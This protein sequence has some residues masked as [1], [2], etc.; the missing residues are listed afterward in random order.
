LWRLEKAG[1]RTDALPSLQ[2]RISFRYSDPVVRQ[3]VAVANFT[4]RAG[5]RLEDVYHQAL[6]RQGI[7]SVVEGFCES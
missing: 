5:L 3:K 1:L 4:Q 7:Q 2:Q 6:A